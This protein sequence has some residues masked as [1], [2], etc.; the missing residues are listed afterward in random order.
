VNNEIKMTY[1]EEAVAY[2]KVVLMFQHLPGR[3]REAVNNLSEDS[4][5]PRR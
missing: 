5:C 3:R 2:V 1:R 4:L